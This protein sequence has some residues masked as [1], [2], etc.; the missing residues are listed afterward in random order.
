MNMACFEKST[1]CG[2]NRFSITEILGLPIQ[3]RIRLV[4]LIWDS[5]AAVPEAVEVSPALKAELE[6]R[7][8]EFEENPEA[9]YSWDEV[10]SR[11]KDGSWLSA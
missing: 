8:K 7:L 2:M 5:V 1:I 3:E 10:K 9:G 6:A 4:E 11:I